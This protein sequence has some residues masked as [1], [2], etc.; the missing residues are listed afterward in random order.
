MNYLTP[1]CPATERFAI[2]IMGDSTWLFPAVETIHLAAMVLLVAS[3]SAFDLRLL[4]F[5]LKG[6]RVSQ[7]MRRLL[8]LTWIAFGTMAVTGVLLFSSDP[9]HKYCPNASFQLKLVLIA[10]AGLNMSLFHFTVY[11]SVAKWDTDQSPPFWAKMVGTISVV[12]W[13]G[14]VVTGRWIGFI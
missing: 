6:E 12:L 2:F 5:I 13:A 1:F 11:R 14:V 7:L 3:I 8:P 10:L 4:G 9:V